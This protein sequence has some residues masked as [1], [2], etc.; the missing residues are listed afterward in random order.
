MIRILWFAKLKEAMGKDETLWSEVPLR[1]SGLKQELQERY[2][3]LPSLDGVMV[4]VNEQY[5]DENTEL[6]DGDTIAFIPPV[7]G[8]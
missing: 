4:A 3:D 7:S 8:G 1:V 2:S 5:A 6:K